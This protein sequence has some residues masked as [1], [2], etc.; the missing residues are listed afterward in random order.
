MTEYPARVKAW[1]ARRDLQD[2]VV[3]ADVNTIYD[4]VTAIEQNLGAGGV[5]ISPTWGGTSFDYTTTTW[6]NLHD[7]INNIESGVFTAYTDRVNTDGGSAIVP[8]T[9][10]TTGLTIKAASGQTANLLEFRDS[11][12]SLI[13]SVSASGA[14]NASYIDGGT[15]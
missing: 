12:N 15:A 1:T 6:N 7:R 11:S 10:S 14:L 8:L 2:L 13:A 5:A 4:E 3:A 9:N